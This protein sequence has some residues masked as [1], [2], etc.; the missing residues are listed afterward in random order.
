MT[1]TYVVEIS[2]EN[3]VLVEARSPR[4]RLD[5][6]LAGG[7]IY[8]SPCVVHAPRSHG[9]VSTIRR[10]HLPRIA[11]PRRR[12]RVPPHFYPLL[13]FLPVGAR[14]DGGLYQPLAPCFPGIGG[15]RVA[16]RRPVKLSHGFRFP[17]CAFRAGGPCKGRSASLPRLV[18]LP[19]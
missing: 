18:R 17:G 10:L 16:G 13:P 2:G 12:Q 7:Q 1:L 6:R 11:L 9:R 3:D 4:R 8:L 19:Q 5:E 15:V 14:G